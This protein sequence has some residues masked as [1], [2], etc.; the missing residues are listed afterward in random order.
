VAATGSYP[1]DPLD[2]G[3]QYEERD[4]SEQY[5]HN[6]HVCTIGEEPSRPRDDPRGGYNDFVTITHR[7]KTQPKR[8][9]YAAGAVSGADGNPMKRP[10]MAYPAKPE[11]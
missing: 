3:Q 11:R 6:V 2:Q 7:R 4:D 8:P 5:G 10:A 9:R 1:V